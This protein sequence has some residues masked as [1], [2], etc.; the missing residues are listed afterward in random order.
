M[1]MATKQQ[2]QMIEQII[3]EFDFDRMHTVMVALDWQWQTTAGNGLAIPSKER[4]I[5]AAQCHLRN[6][7]RTGYCAS[8]GLVARY[9]PG[10][11]KGAEWFELEF[12]V[13]GADNC[14]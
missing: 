1:I 7:I 12:V 9:H 3:D 10:D 11:D 8:G 6:C 4:L 5:A 2:E 14:D 13:C